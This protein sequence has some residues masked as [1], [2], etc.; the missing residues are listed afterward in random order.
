MKIPK[1]TDPYQAFHTLLDIYES[2]PNRRSA[3]AFKP[4]YENLRYAAI[5]GYHQ[6]IHQA[7]QVGAVLIVPEKP[8]L[9][10]S[11]FK[12][13]RLENAS[14]LYRFCNREPL[15]SVTSKHFD[16]LI[17][18]TTSTA[19]WLL[20]EILAACQKWQIQAAYEGL[21][22]KQVDEAKILFQLLE[23]IVENDL[24]ELDVRSFG[25]EA[26]G[27]SKS[28]ERQLTRVTSILKRVFELEGETPEEILEHFG[29]TRFPDPA[30]V[31]GPLRLLKN[32]IEI[33]I[34]L[35]K[36]FFTIN[37]HDIE[38]IQSSSVPQYVLSIENKTTFNRYVREISDGGLVLYTGGFPSRCIIS[39]FNQLVNLYEN[40]TQWYHWGDIDAGG[41]RIFR[42]LE[43]KVFEPSS[44][45][46]RPHLMSKQQA[47]EFGLK[48]KK[49]LNVK[50][51]A[52]SNS[53]IS[54]LAEYLC[55]A[56]PCT[57]EQERQELRA[58][59]Y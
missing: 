21:S 54:S 56:N 26:C 40:N 27:D 57:L 36:P 29:I 44:I 46:L 59:S 10:A 24:P 3:I 25:I 48:V 9:E 16:F 13:V 53:A 11:K 23:T 15:T 17:G 14:S 41:L 20:D 34:H 4:D 2:Q 39:L 18:S 28:L 7:E 35:Q 52:N 38:N 6:I 43:T 5:E 58:P 1:F 12:S 42:H 8:N 50:S 19:E 37:L 47:M 22:V 51:I 30:W 45:P 31:K 55:E 32:E 33:P 49:N